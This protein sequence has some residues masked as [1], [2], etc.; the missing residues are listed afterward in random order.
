MPALLLEG[1]LV[2]DAGGVQ[3]SIQVHIHKVVE[4]LGVG[5]GHGVAGAVRVGERVQ[6]GVQAAFH[7]L[8][9]GLLDGVFPGEG[10]GGGRKVGKGGERCISILL[11][12]GR[13]TDRS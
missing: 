11:E 5:G 6:E 3:H 10:G 7:Q 13:A 2:S 4:V 8:D 12:R 9:K 1:L